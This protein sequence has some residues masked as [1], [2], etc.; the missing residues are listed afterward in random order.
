VVVAQDE[1]VARAV[2]R[3]RAQRPTVAKAPADAVEVAR[4]AEGDRAVQLSFSVAV[5]GL[6]RRGMATANNTA[7]SQLCLGCKIRP[8]PTFPILICRDR[9]SFFY[10]YRDRFQA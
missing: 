10:L 9:P 6:N 2:L 5:S 4:N 7:L 8:I 3:E 1:L